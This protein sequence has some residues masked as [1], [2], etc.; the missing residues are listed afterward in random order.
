MLIKWAKSIIAQIDRL[1]YWHPTLS[2]DHTPELNSF[3][4]SQIITCLYTWKKIIVFLLL[5]SKNQ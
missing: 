2:R 1:V 4:D 3:G 5:T